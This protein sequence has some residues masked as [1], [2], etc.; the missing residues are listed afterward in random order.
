MVP[1]ACR[2]AAAMTPRLM[3]CGEAGQLAA[4]D[5]VCPLDRGAGRSR[6]PDARRMSSARH[7][8]GSRARRPAHGIRGFRRLLAPGADRDWRRRRARRDD[9]RAA[10]R[11]DPGRPGRSGRLDRPGPRA[12]GESQ[13]P[14]PST[15]RPSG[16]CDPVIDAWRSAWLEPVNG[17]VRRFMGRA[18]GGGIVPLSD[19]EAP[20][21][22]GVSPASRRTSSPGAPRPHT[23]EAPPG[24]SIRHMPAA[25]ITPA[26]PASRG[27]LSLPP[28]ASLPSCGNAR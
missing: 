17:R 19:E 8:P 13:P 1:I 9:R 6:R 5:A 3:L 28:A 12:T 2:A 16:F 24:I 14:W 26:I 11:V 23:T 7:R 18:A 10:L 4:G 15:A 22:G 27:L 25:R 20:R 21:C